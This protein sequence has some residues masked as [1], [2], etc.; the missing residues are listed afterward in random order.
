MV[1]NKKKLQKIEIT[2]QDIWAWTKPKTHKDKKKY[3][4]K[5]KYK[6]NCYSW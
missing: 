4:R 2:M 3:S 1:L 5:I 6:K